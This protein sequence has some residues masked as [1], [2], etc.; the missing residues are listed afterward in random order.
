MNLTAMDLNLLVDCVDEARASLDHQQDAGT[1]SEA[2]AITWQ[3]AIEKAYDFLL[4]HDGPLLVGSDGSAM[5]PSASTSGVFYSANGTCSC[6]G[7]THHL[8]CWH[9]AAARLITRYR[10]ALEAKADQLMHL[11]DAA[12]QRGNTLG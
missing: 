5:I 6:K 12:E 4:T 10:E 8:P 7:Y 9:R 11:V 1:L 2:Q 3:R